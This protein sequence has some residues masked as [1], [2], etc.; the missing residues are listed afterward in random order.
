MPTQQTTNVPMR[1]P[2]VIDTESRDKYGDKD[3]QLVNC[4]CEKMPNGDVHIFR[5]PG[6]KIWGQP[7]GSGHAGQGLTYWN[8]AVY[9]IFAGKIYKN[10]SSTGDVPFDS[11]GGVYSFSSIM[12]AT[13][14]LVFQ[15]GVKGYAYD[16]LHNVST[17]LHTLNAEY[18]EYT[19]KGLAYLD[20]TLYVMQRRFGTDIT[21]AVIWG[22]QIDDVV[23]PGAWDPLNFVTARIEP[24][25]GV[26]LAKQ[27]S[28]VVALKEW[29]CEVFFDKGNATGSPLMNMPN[30]KLSM[31][32]ASADSVQRIDDMLVFIATS[33]GSSNQVLL[34]AGLK[35]TI[36]STPAIDRILE[37]ADLSVVYSWQIKQNG[38]SFY[39]LT[40]KNENI[41]L[42]YDLTQNMW[43]RWTDAAG[44]YLPIVASCRDFSGNHI[45]QHETNGA[46]YYANSTY[47]DDDGALI[48]VEIITPNFD[49]G[50]RRQKYLSML[51]FICDQ[52]PGAIQV[53]YSDNDYRTWAEDQK[54]LTGV[55]Y[56]TLVDMGT[57]RKRAFRF[58]IRSNDWFRLQAIEAQ[59]DLGAL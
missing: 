3:A 44:D 37:T 28:Y 59:F 52:S 45:L 57:F 38:H 14:R 49:G 32:C 11:T 36:I 22:S 50:T 58:R 40:I 53:S 13:P 51:G 39:V 7:V 20:G 10:V 5:R 29:T 43:S 4:Y 42:A 35:G 26:Y 2:L 24:D 21:P 56:P 25:S 12:G 27:L 1:I 41:T 47:M 23:S 55:D 15:N 18:P 46:L 19:T 33:Q 9:S 17:D 48:P 16:D 30:A 6:M 34:I 54:V 31:G 8:H